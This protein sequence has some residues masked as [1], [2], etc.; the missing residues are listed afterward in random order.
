ME[1][2][3]NKKL[4]AALSYFILTLLFFTNSLSLSFAQQTSLILPD[5]EAGPGQE[6]TVDVVISD[7][8]QAAQA[9]IFIVFDPE[10]ANVVDA[11]SIVRGPDLEEEMFFITPSVKDL[12]LQNGVFISDCASTLGTVNTMGISSGIFPKNFPPD[13]ISNGTVL[14]IIFR[15]NP[16]TT[17][18]DMTELAI[19]TQS[20]FATNF[21]SAQGQTLSSDDLNLVNGSIT[22]V[23]GNLGSGCTITYSSAPLQTSIVNIFL[24]ITPLI[25][26]TIR[27]NSG[28]LKKSKWGYKSV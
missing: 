17:I 24:F 25:L 18:G 20:F 3:L 1:I 23:Q 27:R 7:N 13:L 5:V 16:E 12:C 4:K 6:V 22:V 14:R 2:Y 10:I 8:T 21:S 11:F 28:K 15:V 26:I 9:G 19:S